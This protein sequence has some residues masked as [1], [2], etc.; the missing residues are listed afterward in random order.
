M[1]IARFEKRQR[2]IYLLAM[3]LSALALAGCGTTK[4]AREVNYSGFLGDYTQLKKTEGSGPILYYGNPKADC[5]KYGKIIINPVTFWAKAADS[6]LAKL[7]PNDQG[8]LVSE[9]TK[10]MRYAVAHGGFKTATEPGP[11]IMVIGAIT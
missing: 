9:A 10:A 2:R 6:P 3:S 1:A 4:S 8:L 11:G 7:A 5:R